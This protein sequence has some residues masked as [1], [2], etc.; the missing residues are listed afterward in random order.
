MYFIYI[1]YSQSS[2]KYYVGYSSDPQR[3][4]LEHNTKPFNTYT[5]KSR[6]WVLKAVFNCGDEKAVAMKFETYIK[7]QKSKLFILKLISDRELPPT[8]AKLVRVPI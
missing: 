3:R 6:P 5:S 4:L 1:L 8:L 7:K 2:D